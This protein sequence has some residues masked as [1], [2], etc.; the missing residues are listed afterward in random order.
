MRRPRIRKAFAAAGPHRARGTRNGRISLKAMAESTS[1]EMLALRSNSGAYSGPPG[2]IARRRAGLLQ[3]GKRQACVDWIAINVPTAIGRAKKFPKYLATPYF[4]GNFT[5][6]AQSPLLRAQA[7]DCLGAAQSVGGKYATPPLT[8]RTCPERR[9]R[10]PANPVGAAVGFARRQA[11]QSTPRLSRLKPAHLPVGIAGCVG[12]Q[13]LFSK[14]RTELSREICELVNRCL[15]GQQSAIV[16]LVDRYRGRVFGLCYRMLGHLHDAEDVTQE[17]LVR[18]CADLPAGTRPATL[19]PGYWPLRAIAAGL[20]WPLVRGGRR[21]YRWPILCRW[22]IRRS[23]R[24]AARRD[25]THCP[26]R[27]GWRWRRCGPSTG[28][29]S[30][31]FTSSS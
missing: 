31:C 9:R 8:S 2:D 20:G 6:F 7:T 15:A 19:S 5:V 13:P 27:S 14:G 16:E 24:A 17:S 28:R 23:T 21:P 10:W 18:A 3:T 25:S 1:R 26:R 29:P 12:S 22:P 30:C 11:V 4:R